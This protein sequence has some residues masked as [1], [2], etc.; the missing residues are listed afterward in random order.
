ME[1]LTQSLQKYL[2]SIYDLVLLNT[3]CRVKD[4]S[5][6]MSVGMASSSEAVKSLAKKGYVNYEPYGII[7]ITAKGK[8]A[9]DMINARRNIVSDF[10]K[11]VLMIDE[12]DLEICTNNLEY[13][14]PEKVLLQLVSYINFM[15]KCSCSK[16]KWKKSFEDFAQ[17]GEMPVGCQNC[18]NGCSCSCGK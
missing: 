17:N 12:K 18:Q 9:V 7:T 6:K 13:Y 15:N 4:V 11:K 2:V 1:N 5:A 8:K 14:V 16:P 10:L 3:A